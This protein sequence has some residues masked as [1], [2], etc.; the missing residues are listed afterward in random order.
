[1]NLTGIDNTCGCCQIQVPSTPEKV[2][3]RPGLSAI[4]YRIGTYAS[5]R[6]AMIEEI[7]SYRLK[8]SGAQVR[9][10]QGWTSRNSD[11]YGIAVLEMWAYL[12]DILT[13][14]QERIA[15]EAY[16]RTAILPESVRRLAALL[17]YKPSPGVAAEALL[18]FTAEKDK[19]VQIPIG[20]KVQ[21]NPG[22][23]EKPQKFETVEAI[24]AE[25]GLNLVRAFPEPELFNPLALGGFEGTLISGSSGLVSG[26][27]LV[28][29]DKDRAET[30]VV[31]KI[32]DKDGQTVLEWD[33]PIQE[34]GFELFTAGVAPYRRQFGLFGRNLPDSYLKPETFV[35]D[36]KTAD[37]KWVLTDIPFKL[38]VFLDLPRESSN[39]FKT[40][41]LDSRYDDLKPGTT[42]LLSNPGSENLGFTRLAKVVEVTSHPTSLEFLQDTVT[43]VTLDLGIRGTI[44]PS[45]DNFGRLETLC[46]GDDGALW[47]IVQESSD[48]WGSWV[49][50]GGKIDMLAVGKNQDGRLEVF[51]RGSD[52]A[53]WY[54]KQ[55]PPNN[56]RQTSPNNGWSKW[57][58]L[59]DLKIDMLAVGSNQDGRLEVFARGMD[60]ALWHIRQTSPNNDWSKWESLGDLKIDML[61][62]GSNQDGRLEVF[63][64]GLDKALW[65]IRQT[66]PNNGWSTWATLGGQIDMLTVGSNQDGRLE[67][68]AR[69]LDKALLHKWQTSPNNGWSTWASIGVPMWPIE[70]LRKVTIYEL[71]MPP[72]QF[73]SLRYPKVISDV[74][75]VFYVPSVQP[76]SIEPKRTLILDDQKAEPQTVTVTDRFPVDLLGKGVSDYLGIT[77]TPALKR[78]LDSATA[79]MYG[80]VA[81]ATQGETV[82]NE[83][84]GDGDA[85]SVFQAFPLSKYPVTF[86]HQEGAHHGA[87]NT[88]QVW[89]DGLR[90]HEVNSFYGQG[91]GDR[92][93][94]TDID[95][96]NK[97]TIL[98][99]NGINGSLLTS[100]SGNVTATYRQGLGREGNVGVG[101]LKTLLDRPLGLKSVINPA[102]ASGGADPEAMD[103][104]RKNA[105]NTVRTFD[106]IVSLRDFEDAARE[107][108][109]IAKA[110]SNWE[111]DGEEQVVKLVVACNDDADLSDE[112]RKQL[113]GYLNF[114]RDTNHRL[115]VQDRIK[116][117]VLINVGIDVDPDHIKERV[118]SEVVD[119]L[120]SYF[121]FDNRDLGSPVHLSEVYSVIQSV[122]GVVAGL[123]HQLQFKGMSYSDMSRRNI[124]FHAGAGT[125]IPDPVQEHLLVYPEEMIVIEDTT[126]DISVVLG[127]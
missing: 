45:L 81:G 27:K 88:L 80:N 110:R 85:S 102:Q 124:H 119:A 28:V 96:N 54:I 49:S 115:R 46:V 8:I 106:R 55:L 6:E 82:S 72:L 16:L 91:K 25:A 4:G 79:V 57:E 40:L 37:I 23:N 7:A 29:F 105:P 101:S 53:L 20:L 32:S 78:D 60:Q 69:G 86:F 14:Y 47:T 109:G 89:V 126:T 93:F 33:P 77:F 71:T 63:A 5:F 34:T 122:D 74:D 111:W 31:Q 100:G 118:L 120:K 87:A 62:V 52:Q 64:R 61:A 48:K 38:Q 107:F 1:M 112:V 75:S 68:F 104:A 18:A 51:A 39:S 76:G 116:M 3:N 36:K 24:K 13:F 11:D 113:I 98:F 58:S 12:A 99:G 26:D 97:M 35:N 66:S 121:S 65:H 114:R 125:N 70:D 19:K 84:L 44:V 73:W 22:Q 56:I 95:S 127:V 108:A 43:E 21:S 103:T 50:R 92:V 17:D 123:I 41:D 117:P 90:W 83:V 42:L 15:N 10:L 67:V 94:K 9:V 59:G 2:Y 30:K